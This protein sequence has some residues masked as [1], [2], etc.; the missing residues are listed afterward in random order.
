MPKEG[1]DVAAP[2]VS[3][4]PGRPTDIALAGGIVFILSI[5]FLP[6][7]TFLI[8]LGLAVS[9]ALSVLILMVSLWIARQGIHHLVSQRSAH[10]VRFLGNVKYLERLVGRARDVGSGDGPGGGFPKTGQDPEQRRLA[11]AVG[12]GDKKVLPG[13][14]G[15][16]YLLDE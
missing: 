10:Q 11:G 1:S 7:P 9:L 3:T 4:L 15:E 2:A 16:V 14:K 5:L 13:R 12:S 6:V 8:D